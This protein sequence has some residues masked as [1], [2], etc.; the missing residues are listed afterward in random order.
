MF[1]ILILSIHEQFDPHCCGSLPNMENT[2]ELEKFTKKIVSV[3]CSSFV[4][5]YQ[6]GILHGLAQGRRR[7]IG[8]LGLMVWT[9]LL[10]SRVS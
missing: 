2:I 3:T 7:L 10:D 9:D 6:P 1:G 8:M 4:A 5:H